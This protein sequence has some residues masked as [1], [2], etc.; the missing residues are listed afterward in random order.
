MVIMKRTE[1]ARGDLQ[2]GSERLGL[3][4]LGWRDRGLAPECKDQLI[5]PKGTEHEDSR[6]VESV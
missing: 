3:N 5:P 6:E 1:L 2:C 4:L